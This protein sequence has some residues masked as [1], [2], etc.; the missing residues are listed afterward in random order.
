[1]RCRREDRL[2]QRAMGLD[3]LPATWRGHGVKVALVD[4]GVA[5]GHRQLGGITRGI[6]IVGR[7]ERGWQSDETGHGSHGAGIIAGLG[8]GLGAGRGADG[9]SSEGITLRGFAPDAEV[10]VCRIF[11]GGRFSDL[12]RAI[13]YGLA[14]GVDLITLGA[15]SP[16]GSQIVER[17]I[18][19]AK[20][21]GVACVAAAGNS[22]GPVAYPAASPMSW[23]CGARPGRRVP[24][25]QLPRH[26]V[27]RRP[28]RRGE[29]RRVR[30][31]P[32]PATARRSTSP[33]PA[34]R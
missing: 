24:A 2:G 26:P 17:R 21:L 18:A 3:R 13:D 31:A 14:Q 32:F 7:S 19:L 34:S 23:R 27:D 33:R 1:M 22:A 5:S 10:H 12:I 28:G 9:P 8:A 16:H 4:S 29:R 25:R 6:D 11:P 30:R 15:G 20:Q